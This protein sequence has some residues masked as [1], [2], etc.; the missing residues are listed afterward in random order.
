MN[1]FTSGLVPLF[2]LLA[3]VG[4]SSDPTGDLRGD[5]SEIV[6]S[7]SQLFLEVGGTKTVEVGA[8]DAQGNPLQF[9]YEVTATGSGIAVRRDS[10]FLP[11]FV[12]DS[13]LQ[14][15]ATAERFRFIVEGM[16]YTATSFTVSA[17]GLDV[18]VPVQVVPEQGFTATFDDDTVDLG[19]VV[20][21]TAPAGVTFADTAFLTLGTDSASLANP[22]TI[23][24][25]DATTFTFIPPPSV[26]S[27]VTVNGVISASA[28]G[29]AF[30]PATQT[31]LVT[32]LV[33][34]VDVTFSTV[35]PV[36]GQ[37]VTMTVPNPLINL[38]V[39]SIIFP[40]QIPGR[41]G[42]PQNIVVAADS[43]SLTFDTPPNI[44]GS[45]TVVNFAFPGG[46]LRGLP[47]RPTVTAPNI[48]TTI[49]ATFSDTLPDLLQV[50]TVTAPPGFKFDTSSADTLGT[51]AFGVTIGGNLSILQSV[52]DDGSSATILPL[53]GSAGVGSIDGVVPDAAP[54]NIVTMLTVQTVTV[55]PLI[56]LEGTDD[57]ATAPVLTTPGTTVDA[58]TFDATNC[59][60]FPENGAPCQVYRL[61]YAAPTTFTYTLTGAN[62]ADLGLYF[63]NAAD[64]SARDEFCD[65]AGRASPPESCSISLP[66]GEYILAVINFGPLYPEEDPDP[67]F[68]EIRIE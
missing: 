32:P 60:G 3:L 6:A 14:A 4:C 8:V 27:P 42:D 25:Q 24:S 31:T 26:N 9:N 49:D 28:P 59:P 34:T 55:P 48:G 61:S 65:G 38:V 36:L 51:P 18:V 62:P 64:M 47:T 41:E 53:P 22:L 67:P 50:I 2:G 54:S 1:R 12:N 66:A 40:G 35:T 57:P 46:Y 16:G 19:Q 7:P 44:S 5:P 37:T 39:D 56:P 29:Q 17:G 58:G 30:A 11:V 10:S 45:G 63:Y 23:V 15:P 68:I 52:A 43:S 21:L 20:T 13:T 33:D